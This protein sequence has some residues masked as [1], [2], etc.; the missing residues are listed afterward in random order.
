MSANKPTGNSDLADIF[1]A[2]KQNKGR[3]KVA[4]AAKE[5]VVGAGKKHSKKPTE[6]P[7]TSKTLSSKKDKNSNDQVTGSI[8]KKGSKV[9]KETP[10]GLF[11]APD[12]REEAMEMPDD[13]FFNLRSSGEVKGSGGK[14]QRGADDVDRMITEDQLLRMVRKQNKSGNKPGTTPLCPFD[15]DCCY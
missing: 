12:E 5:E 3:E 11:V 1:S 4:V 9:L 7:H 6:G 10:V 15:C 2:L 13:A 8:S 14:K